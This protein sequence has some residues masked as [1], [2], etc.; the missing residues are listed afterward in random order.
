M[1]IPYQTSI[2]MQTIVTTMDGLET[3]NPIPICRRDSEGFIILHRESDLFDLP[4]CI[5]LGIFVLFICLISYHW[6]KSRCG[7]TKKKERVTNTAENPIFLT[8]SMPLNPSA[9]RYVYRTELQ[10]F[11]P[12]YSDPIEFQAPLLTH[13][14]ENPSVS[15]TITVKPPVRIFSSDPSLEGENYRSE[16]L[17]NGNNDGNGEF[18]I[19]WDDLN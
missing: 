16:I 10:E 6:T 3:K 1:H 7:R 18:I 17:I 11:R 9:E 19:H 8:E 14:N 4:I 15:N 13:A 12:A 5:F 2:S